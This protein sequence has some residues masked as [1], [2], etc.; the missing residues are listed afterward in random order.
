MSLV[1]RDTILARG[2]TRRSARPRRM[3]AL[4][5][6]HGGYVRG[7]TFGLGGVS[8]SPVVTDA[9]S[10]ATLA[11]KFSL[12]ITVGM[13]GYSFLSRFVV[14]LDYRAA[15]MT[16]RDPDTYVHAGPTAA[17]PITLDQGVP[18]VEASVVG[19]DGDVT[20]GHFIVDT[21]CECL[22]DHEGYPVRG[23]ASAGSRR[24][25][26]FGSVPPRSPCRAC[27][28]AGSSGPA[29]AR[30]DFDGSLGAFVGDAFRIVLDYRHQRIWLDPY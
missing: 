3:A 9:T 13:L 17:I 28:A 11:P 22:F 10:L 21:G 2:L 25:P 30:R 6:L 27:R 14:D 24:P 20:V 8:F 19:R 29:H 23:S 18:H 4:G 15:T 5:K 16:L 12:E 7:V 1:D 26:R